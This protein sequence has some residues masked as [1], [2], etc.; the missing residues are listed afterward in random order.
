MPEH[1]RTA[2]QSGETATV[3]NASHNAGD[4]RRRSQRGERRLCPQKHAIRGD[5]RTHVLNVSKKRIASVLRQRHHR[6]AS[7]LAVQSQPSGPPVDIGQAQLP[8]VAGPQGQPREQQD[9]GAIPDFDGRS[10]AAGGDDLFNRRDGD[11]ARHG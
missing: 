1:M 3:Q 7:A 10:R 8:Y 5:G 4:L 6:C 2:R 11:R 9:D